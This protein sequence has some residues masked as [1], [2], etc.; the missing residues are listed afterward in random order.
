MNKKRINTLRVIRPNWNN[1]ERFQAMMKLLKKYECGIGSIT[2]LTA[3]NHAPLT[4]EEMEKSLVRIKECMEEAR[5]QGYQA[6]INIIATIGHHSENQDYCLQGDY[7]HMTGIDGRICQGSFCMNDKTY[8][9]EYVVPVYRMMAETKPDFIWIDDD[10]RCRHVPVGYGCFCDNCIKIFNEENRTSYTRKSL[11]DE[12]NRGNVE[13]RKK[14]LK[15]NSDS[16]VNLMKLIG[17]TVR[18][19]SD[20]IK[21]GFMTGDR[22]FE[23]Y[24]FERYA[25]ALSDG[26]K[27]EIMWRP[28]GGAYT[29]HSFDDIVE[30]AGEIGRQCAYLPDYV[31]TIQSEIENFPYDIIQKSPQSTAQEILLHIAAGCN[32]AALNILP[33]VT[34]VRDLAEPDH[35][36][37]IE[38][39]EK[40]L[41][42]I[43]E[44]YKFESLLVDKIY[45]L[46]PCGVHTG[47]KTDSQAAVSGDEWTECK[48]TIEFG[49]YANE[50]LDLGLP[51]AYHLEQ[52]QVVVLRKKA[53]AVMSDEEIKNIL[54]GGV[55]MDAEALDYINARGFYEYTGF[56]LGKEHPFDA[57]EHYLNDVLNY[58][59]V[60][61]KRNCRQP[62]YPGESFS[63]IPTNK[64]ARM[65]SELVDYHSVRMADCALGVFENK[66]GGRI[67][68][69]GYYPFNKVSFRQKSIQIKRIFSYLSGDGLL[70]Y[71]KSHERARL[72]SY[73]GVDKSYVVLFNITNDGYENIEI[74]LNTDV[75]TVKVYDRFHVED[76]TEIKLEE[77]KGEKLLKV[78]KMLPYEMLLIEL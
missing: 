40:H 7:T 2:F 22:F 33:G 61:G 64:D 69:A 1:D 15:K 77:E 4:V 78:E 24:E 48:A 58:G 71:V 26:G 37:P 38:A 57:H 10:V 51:Q 29:D 34:D 21:L 25:E 41:Q 70:A 19:V 3:F 32:G 36:E 35:D 53:A 5:R 67:C 75:D 20:K 68:V 60:G 39:I 73:K 50:L 62:F 18:E 76:Y 9:E 14:Y 54:S 74:V 17:T 59:I 31:T 47:W 42:K 43:D 49:N 46:S 66:L 56:R 44:V 16:I 72:W 27:Y 28:G 6:G 63:L 45:K 23:G 13:L 8:L 55:Y 12:L 52:A 30:K 65:L 11:R